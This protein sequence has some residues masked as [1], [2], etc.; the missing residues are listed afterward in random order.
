MLN[1]F[2]EN[3]L[4]YILGIQL[5]KKKSD[6]VQKKKII[7]SGRGRFSR[8][9]KYF[10]VIMQFSSRQSCCIINSSGSLAVRRRQQHLSWHP[11]LLM[12]VVNLTNNEGISKFTFHFLNNSAHM[13]LELRPDD[14]NT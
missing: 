13:G 6:K 10:L 8:P 12:N 5:P 1:L 7:N 4:V 9:Q 14:N 2:V 11:T 3:F